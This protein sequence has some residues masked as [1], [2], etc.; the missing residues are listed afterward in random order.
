[1]QQTMNV[2]LLIF[3]TIIVGLLADVALG[4]YGQPVASALVW[5]VFLLVW[6]STPKPGR[7][8]LASVLAIATAAECFLSLAWGLYSYRLENV[9]MF[10]PPGHVILFFLGMRLAER[11]PKST[12]WIVPLAFAPIVAAFAWSGRDTMG[13]VYFAFFLACL[14]ISPSRRL[15][16]TMFVL[17]LAMEIYGTWLGNWNWAAVVPWVGLTS[18]NP[19]LAAGAFYCVLDL[20]VVSIAARSAR[21]P[22]LEADRGLAPGGDLQGALVPAMA[23]DDLKA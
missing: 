1:M 23:A 11:V 16:S 19:P 8:A 22:R 18:F 15:Y 17:S 13:V 5:L 21:Q 6:R 10:V 2:E 20:I 14:W 9:P 12:E 3:A 4:A 7:L